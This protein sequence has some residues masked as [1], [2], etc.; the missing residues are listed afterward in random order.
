VYWESCAEKRARSENTSKEQVAKTV[1]RWLKDEG[2][3]VWE[4][5]D[6]Q[7]DF[8]FATRQG[9]TNIN[10][11]F[12]KTSIDSLI[13][14]GNLHFEQQEQTMLRYTKTKHDLIYE[15]E[16]LFIQ[17]NLDFILKTNNLQEEF[18]IEDIILQKTI[19]FDGLSKDRLFNVLSLI[20][21]CL[22]V[23]IFKFNSLGRR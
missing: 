6:D 13:V 17:M 16:I 21:N 14:Q 23:L 15:L 19:Y 22:K 12:H 18:T 10:I 5:K 1:R 3:P 2:L 20:F 7:T 4:R 11:G 9:N 8:N